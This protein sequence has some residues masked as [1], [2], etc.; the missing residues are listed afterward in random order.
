MATLVDFQEYL[1]EQLKDPE[2]KKGFE[3]EK[4]KI[5]LEEIVN[6]FLQKAGYE[7]YCVEVMDID[8]Y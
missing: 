1:D 2:F 3:I 4:E 8:D 6:G 5:N 7:K